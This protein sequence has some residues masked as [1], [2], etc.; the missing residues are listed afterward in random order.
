[1]APVNK[2]VTAAQFAASV[3]DFGDAVESAN[4]LIYGDPGCGKTYLTAGLPNLL[5]LACDPN[6][7]VARRAG[8]K[9]SGFR[10]MNRYQELDG[11]LDWLEQ[12][13]A[14]EFDWVLLDGV[15]ILQNRILF[16]VAREA[17]EANPAKRANPRQPDKPDYFFAQNAIK[18]AVS[19]LVDLPTNVI[20]TAHAMDLE[21]PNTG[22]RWLRPGIEGKGFAVSNY[23]CGLMSAVGYMAPKVLER[24]GKKNQVRRILWRTIVDDDA[25]VTYFAKDQLGPAFEQYEDNMTPDTLHAKVTGT[26]TTSPA[27]TPKKTAATRR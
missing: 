20:L 25:G 16:Q 15:N 12:G 5:Y 7:V 6:W 13:A 10:K 23:I 14:E 24:V 9:P 4:I 2:P 19:R 1:M 17:W 18:S 21:D 8:H 27:P 11:A 22:E 26:A 3:G